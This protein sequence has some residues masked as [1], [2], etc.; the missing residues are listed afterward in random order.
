MRRRLVPALRMR[1]GG[2][3]CCLAVSVTLSVV[4]S[5]DNYNKETLLCNMYFSLQNGS[6]EGR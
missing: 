2:C 5:A 1:G 6:N 4:S 3:E